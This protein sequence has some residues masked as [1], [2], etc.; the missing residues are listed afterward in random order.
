MAGRTLEG[1]SAGSGQFDSDITDGR[2][3]RAALGLGADELIAVASEGR[4]TAR[5]G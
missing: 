5:P 4:A 3:P 1:F 2:Y